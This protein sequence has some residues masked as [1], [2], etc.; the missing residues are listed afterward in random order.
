MLIEFCHAKIT[1]ATITQAELFYE[2]SITL[3]RDI[4]EAADIVPG[5]KVQIVN[6]NN[7]QRFDTYTIA[8]EAGS[9][10]VCL[11]GPAARLGVVGDRIHILSYAL[12]ERH[13]ARDMSTRVVALD[14]NNKIS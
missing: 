3:D 10:T 14:A 9:G 1:Y 6:L 2:G 8:G 13:K 11:N 7:G 4:L 12:I 5:Q